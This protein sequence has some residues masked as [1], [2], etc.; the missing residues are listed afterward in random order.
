MDEW[1]VEGYQ[2]IFKVMS[3]KFVW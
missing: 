1:D 3:L 2:N